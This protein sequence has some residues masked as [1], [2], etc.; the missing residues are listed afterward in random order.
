M[1]YM[2]KPFQLLVYKLFN[3]KG[4]IKVGLVNKIRMIVKKWL[5]WPRWNL[6]SK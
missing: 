5:S 3:P 2:D 6:K 4:E 1:V